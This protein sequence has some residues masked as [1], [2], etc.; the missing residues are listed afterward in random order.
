V[1]Q[2]NNIQELKERKTKRKT[3]INNNINLDFDMLINRERAFIFIAFAT[4]NKAF[5][6]TFFA[7]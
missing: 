7:S 6:I 3:T 5:L 4:S 2:T 1:R